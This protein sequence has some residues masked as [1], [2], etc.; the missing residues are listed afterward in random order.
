MLQDLTFPDIGR[1]TWERL[2]R[3]R[4][5]KNLLKLE[6]DYAGNLALE[7]SRKSDGVF[8]WVDL[9]TK[10]LLEGLTNADRVVDLQ[11]RLEE[12][13]GDLEALYAKMFESIDWNY[14]ERASRYF[15]IS[16]VATGN[17]SALTLY[18][19]DEEDPML[20]F[21]TKPRSLT[22]E[23]TLAS[24]QAIK[25]RLAGCCKGFLQIPN[26][27]PLEH[28]ESSL[29]GDPPFGG[30]DDCPSDTYNFNN[31]DGKGLKP[32]SESH[33][34]AE[35][36]LHPQNSS[37]RGPH[38]TAA[39]SEANRKVTYIHRTAKDYLESAG[40]KAKILSMPP[41]GF[42][43]PRFVLNA[44]LLILRSLPRGVPQ[45]TLWEVIE[46]FL[47]FAALA[48]SQLRHAITEYVDGLDRIATEMFREYN[49]CEENQCWTDTRWNHKVARNETGFLALVAEFKL[50]LYIKTKIDSGGCNWYLKGWKVLK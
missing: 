13:S 22:D 43:A 12:L 24:Y 42:E 40:M 45:M 39:L 46:N 10:S 32:T 50:P 11:R 31:D 7:I 3:H 9:V 17:L 18:F 49:L 36:D 4:G 35:L 28:F 21:K 47:A 23:M 30:N 2:Y 8:L 20:V 29:L 27:A 25:T 34:P 19:A 33:A 26:P 16:A 48:E 41:S 6:A 15:Q 14:R 5:F 44:Q 37:D 38:D 1:F